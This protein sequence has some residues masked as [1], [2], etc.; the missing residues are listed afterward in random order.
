M[1]RQAGA[2]AWMRP[3]SSSKSGVMSMMKP[4]GGDRAAPAAGDG[5]TRRD[6]RRAENRVR[7]ASLLVFS[8][9]GGA[10]QDQ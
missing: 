8:C 2:M 9:G 1:A 5:G 7:T 6:V 10:G 3:V 4:L